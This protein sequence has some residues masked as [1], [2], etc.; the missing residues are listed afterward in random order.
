EELFGGAAQLAE[1]LTL[2]PIDPLCR[3]FFPDGSQ[4]DLFCDAE[5]TRVAIE[6]FAGARDARGYMEFREH[7]RK[8]HEIV[9]GPF[10]ERPIEVLDLLRPS[11]IMQLTRIDGLRTMW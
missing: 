2:E 8:I 4:L 3:H 7:V 10:M 6:R 5:R 1:Y 11:T 9:R